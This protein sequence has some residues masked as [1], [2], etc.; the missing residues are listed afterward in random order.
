MT[1][2]LSGRVAAVTGA[3]RGI[4]DAIAARLMADG[5]RVFSL[6]KIA[7]PEPRDGVTYLEA[8]VTDP[9]RCR[10]VQAIDGRR[11]DRHPRQQCRHPARRADRQISRRLVGGDLP[12]LNGSSLRVGGGAAHGRAQ[13]GCHRQHRLTAAF[14]GL[15]AAPT[16]P[17]RPVS[18]L[19]RAL[20][21]EV[22][23]SGIRVNAVA[24]GFTRTKFIDQALADGSLQNWM[25]ERVPM[26][27]R[28]RPRRSPTPCASSPAT[29]PPT[30]PGRRSSPTALDGAGIPHAPS[31][32]R[33][34]ATS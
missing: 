32:L 22:A 29:R 14:V 30:S 15:G 3:A 5:A 10:G 6:D 28:R 26:R 34:P 20:A 18:S 33:T 24:P 12:H 13:S 2:T 9:R 16:A 27:R 31:W 25:L 8:D 1:E 21:T 17:P 23:T 11:P 7:A 4:G 19:T